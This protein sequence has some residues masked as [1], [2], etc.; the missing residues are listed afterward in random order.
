VETGFPSGN[1]INK[2]LQQIRVSKKREFAVDRAVVVASA[3]QKE[4]FSPYFGMIE[5]MPW[6]TVRE[7]LR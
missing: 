7:S 1:A 4:R 6:K 5:K 3:I 2:K